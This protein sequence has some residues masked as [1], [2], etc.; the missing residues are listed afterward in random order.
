MRDLLI[1]LS[2]IVVCIAVLRLP[3]GLMLAEEPFH[4]PAATNDIAGMS[5]LLEH[6]YDVNARDDNGD[7]AL[8]YALSHGNLEM[9]DFLLSKG[10]TIDV[11]NRHGYTLASNVRRTGPARARDWL[12]DHGR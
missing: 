6:G 10:A 1:G 11:S 2:A 8:Y 5:R 3:T 12:R 9:A 7:T 4:R